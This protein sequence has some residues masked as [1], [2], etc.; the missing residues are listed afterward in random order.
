MVE[1]YEG[2]FPTRRMD[3]V[4]MAVDYI[5]EAGLGLTP[6]L[7][8]VIPYLESCEA[9][10]NYLVLSAYD[11]ATARVVGGHICSRRQLFSEEYLAYHEFTY[12]HPPYRHLSLGVELIQLSMEWA[13][14]CIATYANTIMIGKSP[15]YCAILSRL[16]FQTTG[17]TYAYTLSG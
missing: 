12:I 17:D 8:Q 11:D 3:Y 15:G 6:D 13:S 9:D 1:V 10:P 4:G 5:A 2:Y 16:G 14:S 7:T